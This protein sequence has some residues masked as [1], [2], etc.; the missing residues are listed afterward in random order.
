[1]GLFNHKSRI[2][3]LNEAV[4]P[5]PILR[6]AMSAISS[7]TRPLPTVGKGHAPDLHGAV[8]PLRKAGKPGLLVAAGAAGLTAASALVSSRRKRQEA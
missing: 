2:D 1:M 7:G 6:S 4:D 8:E 3:R 5:H